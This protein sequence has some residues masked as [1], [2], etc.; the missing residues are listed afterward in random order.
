MVG[1]APLAHA[2]PGGPCAE[3]CRPLPLPGRGLAR[4]SLRYLR[5]VAAR[6]W[7]RGLRLRDPET[8]LEAPELTSAP[9]GRSRAAAGVRAAV[10]VMTSVIV[11][12]S[13]YTRFP[14]WVTA[15]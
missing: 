2:R 1:K 15:Q 3:C 12:V 7:L 9:T 14:F 6:L 13:V 4:A 11:N 5:G 8:R 10:I